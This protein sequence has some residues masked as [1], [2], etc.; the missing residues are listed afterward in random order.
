MDLKLP[1]DMKL[2]WNNR[3][4]STAGL[5][6]YKMDGARPV[7]EIHISTK[8]CD[9]PGKLTIFILKKVYY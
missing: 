8:V 6:K 3:L 1:I 9:T 4:T 2:M 5:C 7:A